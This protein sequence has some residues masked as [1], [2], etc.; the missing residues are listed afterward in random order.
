VINAALASSADFSLRMFVGPQTH[1]FMF[2]DLAAF[3]EMTLCLGSIV[4]ILVVSFSLLPLDF[5]CLPETSEKTIN[6]YRHTD[7]CHFTKVVVVFVFALEHMFV[8]VFIIWSS[9]QQDKKWKWVMR[10]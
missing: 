1:P 2:V 7:S 10:V 3:E 9:K 4:R 5:I 8:W 6:T